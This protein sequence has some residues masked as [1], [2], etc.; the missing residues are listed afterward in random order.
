MNLNGDE[1]YYVKNVQGG[2][3]A[4]KDK[5]GEEVVSYSYDS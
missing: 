3:I 2:I 5:A 4:L 1:Y